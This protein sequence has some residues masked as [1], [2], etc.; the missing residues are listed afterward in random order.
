MSRYLKEPQFQREL[1]EVERIA[2]AGRKGAQSRKYVVTEREYEELEDA[3]SD[4]SRF[5]TLKRIR[6]IGFTP[7]QDVIP[8]VLPKPDGEECK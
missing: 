8:T 3:G 5:T 1:R 7:I 2:R 4:L 6:A